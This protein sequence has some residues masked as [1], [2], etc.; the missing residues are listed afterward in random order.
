MP[1]SISAMA[2]VFIQRKDGTKNK[3]RLPA[4]EGLAITLG[5]NPDC[6]I[7]LPDVVGLSGLHCSICYKDGAFYVKDEGS[8]NG[9]Y[10]IDVRLSSEEPLQEN[11][12]YIIGEATLTYDA[13][14]ATVPALPSA[15][16]P[17]PAVTPAAPKPKNPTN[18]PKRNTVASGDNGKPNVLAGSTIDYSQ[19]KKVDDGFVSTYAIIIVIISFLAGMT[20]RHWKDTGGFFPKEAFQ[21]RPT[22]VKKVTKNSASSTS[23]PKQNPTASA[24]TPIPTPSS[25]NSA[26]SN[27]KQTAMGT[28]K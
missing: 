11:T 18:T 7:S 20:L 13:L 24:T 1:Y 5:R 15:A 8:T 25:T 26:A 22:E 12:E 16:A 17:K 23:T 6:V 27:P 10:R 19:H 28:A 21:E 9:V 3:Y 4:K 2:L 14:G